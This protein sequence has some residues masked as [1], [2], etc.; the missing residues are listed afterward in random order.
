MTRQTFKTADVLRLEVAQ[1]PTGLVNQIKN[2]PCLDAF[3][4]DALDPNIGS[5][6]GW[7]AGSHAR[8][9]QVADT[10]IGGPDHSAGNNWLYWSMPSGAQPWFYS[11]DWTMAPGEYVAARIQAATPSGVTAYARIM[12]EFLDSSGAYI[13]NSAGSTI[14]QATRIDTTGGALVSHAAVSAPAGTARARLRI[15]LYG[16][17]GGGNVGAGLF[18][19]KQATV[20]KASTSAALSGLG[21]ISADPTWTNII[22]P[23]HSITVNRAALNLGILTAEILDASVDP[24]QSTLVRPGKKCR[25][26]ALDSATATWTPLFVGKITQGKT[27]YN[28]R[29]TDAKRARVTLTAVDSLADLSQVN[30][31]T[32]TTD[33]RYMWRVLEGAGVPWYIDSQQ[34]PAVTYSTPA[35]SLA[36]HVAIV[37]DSTL[38]GAWVDRNGVLNLY[39]PANLSARPV[40]A[41]LNESKYSDLDVDYDTD[42]CINVV[43]VKL[44]RI[45][46]ATGQEVEVPYG[47]F[48]DQ[49]SVD[50]WRAHAA[51]FTVVGITDTVAGAKAWA[52]Q[53]LTANATPAVRINSAELPIR[54][55]ADVIRGKALLD[56][57]DRVTVSNTNAGISQTMRIMDLEHQI[58]DGKWQLRLGF[59]IS[60]GVAAPQAV[61]TS[62]VATVATADG[63]WNT[64]AYSDANWSNPAG[65]QAGRYKR[66]N[67]EVT[68]Q[69]YPVRN[70]TA[71]GANAVVGNLPAGFRP[72][73]DFTVPGVTNTGGTITPQLVT[74]KS[75]GDVVI[76]ISVANAAVPLF[77]KIPTN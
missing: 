15:D 59:Q 32:G 65:F 16:T 54:D 52:Q 21:V 7:A 57:Y 8:L 49:A 29:R 72:P 46:A 5:G 64:F 26:M 74:I 39:A 6:Y 1:T 33:Y 27:T 37:R 53:V 22:G 38:S 45:N 48:V 66:E 42:R 18:Y 31:T 55:A 13:T 43:N 51:D 40:V 77:L 75:N 28:P 4:T 47:P 10:S 11:D 56:L 30:K 14:T 69:A 63:V 76:S 2:P 17:A 23:T 3:P 20:A 25:L 36:D 68:L 44:R 70:A 35:R 9:F 50:Q 41:T 61:S 60:T 62:G 12:F 71:S 58:T 19:W 67:G 73:A 24:S 34:D